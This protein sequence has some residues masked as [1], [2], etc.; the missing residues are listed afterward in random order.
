MDET[1]RRILARRKALVAA[2]IVTTTTAC[3]RACL[4]YGAPDAAAPAPCLTA[5]APLV[6][7]KPRATPPVDAGA[8]ADAGAQDGAAR[9]GGG[10]TLTPIDIVSG[11]A[12][13]PVVCLH[14]PPPR[15]CLR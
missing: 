6:C 9:E 3:P 14:A 5:T 8:A 1:R 4:K 2:A 11:D 10:I 15:V 13:A 7:L 12:G